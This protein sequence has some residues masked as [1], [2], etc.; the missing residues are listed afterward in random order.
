MTLFLKRLRKKYKNAIRYF[1]CG[2]YGEKNLRPHYHI[3]LFGHDFEDK[4][5]WQL[6]NGVPLYR[7]KALEG[8]WTLGFSTVGDV[9]YESAAYVARY[10]TKKIT[11]DLAEKH[12][13]S[14]NKE[15]GL[16]SQ[17]KPECVTMSRRPGIGREFYNK[18]KNDIYSVDAVIFKRGN[19]IIK[20]VSPRYYD[21]I[22]DKENPE[23]FKKIKAKRKN[24]GLLKQKDNTDERLLVRENLENKKAKLLKRS[25]ENE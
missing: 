12:Y 14:I 7:S 10:I 9:T 15:T 19:K 8:L 5:F 18:N 21:N 20:A 17:L 22:Y 3:I 1:Q 13:E 6:S 4:K 16:V 24:K 25:Y 23:D 11:G 2:E